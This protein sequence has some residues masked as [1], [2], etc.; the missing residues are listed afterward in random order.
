[1]SLRGN[2]IIPLEKGI[3]YENEGINIDFPS[4]NKSQNNLYICLLEVTILKSEGLVFL[5]K[6]KVWGTDKY[7]RQK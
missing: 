6:V 5:I 4:S 1:M 3:V 2:N 7:E